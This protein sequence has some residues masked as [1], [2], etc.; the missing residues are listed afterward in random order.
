VNDVHKTSQPFLIDNLKHQA[1]YNHIVS[2][3]IQ[4]SAIIIGSVYLFFR[5]WLGEFIFSL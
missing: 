4:R 1:F 5:Y 2:G 3:N